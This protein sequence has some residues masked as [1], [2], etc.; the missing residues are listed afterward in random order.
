M[1]SALAQ[2]VIAGGR[3]FFG[4]QDGTVYS[5]N[6]KT[7]CVYWTFEAAAGVRSAISIEATQKDKYTLTGS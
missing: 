3:I 6:A 1:N 7:G 5:L 4:A 2:P